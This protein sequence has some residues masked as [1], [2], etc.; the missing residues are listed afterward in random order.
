[1]SLIMV[2]PSEELRAEIERERD[3]IDA[4][5]LLEKMSEG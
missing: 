3:A 5:R 2:L 4:A 1:M